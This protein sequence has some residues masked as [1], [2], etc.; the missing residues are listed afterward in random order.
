[1]KKHVMTKRGEKKLVSTK[2]RKN[3]WNKCA[4][5]EW[6]LVRG[7]GDVDVR[8]E[9]HKTITPPPCMMGGTNERCLKSGWYGWL[10]TSVRHRKNLKTASVFAR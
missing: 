6:G 4:E 5:A 10:Q 9:I 2:T 1:L 8:D 3:D 7:G